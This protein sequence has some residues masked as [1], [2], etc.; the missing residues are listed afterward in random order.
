[1]AIKLKSGLWVA[2][3]LKR[4]ELNDI[5]AYLMRRGQEDLGA[6]MVKCAHLNGLATLWH[7]SFD[8]SSG[9][10]GWVVLTQGAEREVD[11]SAAKQARFDP[12]L[13]LI[14]IESR[15]GKTLLDAEGLT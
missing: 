2:A 5:P 1:M 15:D 10:Q 6:V 7:R 13:W 3:Y 8:L 14:E 11:E 4:L 9:A 12:D